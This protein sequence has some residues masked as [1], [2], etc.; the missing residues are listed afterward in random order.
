VENL[1]ADK[2]RMSYGSASSKWR[3]I[4]GHTE[5]EKR[6]V[7]H[8]KA[9]NGM[10]PQNS[11]LELKIWATAYNTILVTMATQT[12]NNRIQNCSKTPL[13]KSSY[14]II[15]RNLMARYCCIDS[16]F[17]PL[18]LFLRITCTAEK[19]EKMPAVIPKVNKPVHILVSREVFR[20]K[21]F[22][23]TAVK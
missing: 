17:L 13:K 19:T 16:L 7:K 14:P 12:S 23:L 1:L 18:S 20:M 4:A 21:G 22:A 8:S 3:K 6:V 5:P 15:N 2:S 9:P 11:C 10:V